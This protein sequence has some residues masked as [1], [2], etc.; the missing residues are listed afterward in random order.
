[1][2]R[3]INMALSNEMM[4]N[5]LAGPKIIDF[6]RVFVYSKNVKYF[7]I[8]NEMKSVIRA[9]LIKK[10][11][12]FEGIEEKQQII[13][14]G[15][16][17]AF[18]IT[19][20]SKHPVIVNEIMCYI[21]NEKH[22][23]KYIAKAEVIKV[24]L[25]MS[26]RKVELTFP[27]DSLEMTTSKFITLE[28]RGNDVAEFNW[29][30]TPGP[31]SADPKT[32]TVEPKEKKKIRI[33]YAPQ[34]NG[35]RPIEE[36]VL[37]LRITHGEPR[38]L[39]VIGNAVDTRCEPHPAV[40][41][42]NSIAVGEVSKLHFSLKNYNPR[43]AAVYQIDQKSLGPYIKINPNHLTGKIPAESSHKIEF[44]FCC[45]EQIHNLNKSFNVLIRGSKTVSVHY[46]GSVIIPTVQIHEPEFDFKMVTYGNSASLSM[47]IENTSPIVAKLN[48]DLRPNEDIPNSDQFPCL[49]VVQDKQSGDDS[50]VIEEMDIDPEEERRK[51]NKA[52]ETEKNQILNQDKSL[53]D[54]MPSEDS[55]ERN[56][57]LSDFSDLPENNDC[58]ILTLKPKKVY[59]F[60][61]TFTPQYTQK[62]EFNLPL[63]LSGFNE[64]TDLQRPVIC[65]AVH[66][67][68]VL[69]PIDGVRDFKKKTISQ[70]DGSSPDT[71]SLKINNPDPDK[72]V[73]F[74]IDTKELDENKVFHLSKTEGLV[75]PK[76]SL[77]I[78]IEF[79][80]TI[81]KE[82]CYKLPLFRR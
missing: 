66:P 80:P 49:K 21:I 57:E 58:F 82:Y 62:Y 19:F 18:P 55:D 76:G 44:E 2:T 34:P 78:I 16:T 59:K 70:I 25:D 7:H 77:E 50:L 3:E 23:F 10:S 60:I 54:F 74:F 51:R 14:T 65:R 8:R 52:I 5:I 29:L 53:D 22:I 71:Q 4:K 38:S 36:D 64:Y 9:R 27:D 20:M 69:D 39:T 33:I 72:P 43:N 68:I 11:D 73:R 26:D 30:G 32:G 28:N 17:A 61:L 13:M 46:A 81:P 45:K 75:A 56:K 41:N 37:D 48:L 42:F 31:F 67:R 40:V 35:I 47:T 24:E 63:T 1:M 12:A 15:R 79:R 6:G